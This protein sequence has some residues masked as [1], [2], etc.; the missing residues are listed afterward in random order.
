MP[1]W[2]E[3]SVEVP[4]EVVESVRDVMAQFG[5]GGAVVEQLIPEDDTLELAP[6]KVTVKIYLPCD[7]EG[8]RKKRELEEA[9]W[10]LG[11]LIPLPAP[12]VR[13]VEEHRWLEAWKEFFPVLHIGSRLVVKP[14]WEDYIS[15]PGE[16]L[17]E[18]EPG[19]AFG[20]GLHPTT[21]LCLV[22]LEKLIHP[23]DR[24]LD[25]GTGSGILALFAAKLG[26]AYTLGIDVDP[27]ALKAAEENV[28]RNGLQGKVEI[29]WGSLIPTG[30][31]PLLNPKD[32][33]E[34]D[35]VLANILAPVIMEM[36]LRLAE[37]LAPKGHLVVSGIVGGQRYAVREALEEAGLELVEERESGDWVGMI[38]RRR[39]DVRRSG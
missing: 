27:M 19:V 16:V 22:A 24:V 12:S 9:L 23:G 3:L 7:E 5:V 4:D 26:A 14:A 10:H 1:K 11:Q 17:V 20:T 36:A 29:R 28:A 6:V 31:A 38:L 2:M 37:V 18:M 30:E 35:L 25:V 21:R 8:R 34:F 33:G 39:E 13:Y 15:R 32:L